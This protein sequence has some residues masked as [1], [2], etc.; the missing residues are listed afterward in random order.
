MTSKERGL[1]WSGRCGRGALASRMRLKRSA[2][3]RLQRREGRIAFTLLSYEPLPLS[4]GC[5]AVSNSPLGGEPLSLPVAASA[6]R[7]ASGTAS[8]EPGSAAVTSA[9]DPN[10]RAAM[11]SP[12]RIRFAT[13]RGASAQVRSGRLAQASAMLGQGTHPPCNRF[14][15]CGPP[16]RD[17]RCRWRSAAGCADHRRS[18]GLPH[19]PRR[20]GPGAQAL[21]CR[22]RRPARAR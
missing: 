20:C 7:S 5:V 2:Q 11:G 9:R 18:C 3:V 17:S 10:S 1:P 4:P 22:R 21:T 12:H 15:R 16:R 19:S 14:R 8:T 13:L 6:L